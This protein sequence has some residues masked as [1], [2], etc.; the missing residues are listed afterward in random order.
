MSATCLLVT[1]CASQFFF[2]ATLGLLLVPNTSAGGLITHEIYALKLVDLDGRT[3]LTNDG[4]VTVVVLTTRTAI[5]KA[6]LVGARVPDYCLGNPE[7]RMITVVSFARNYGTVARALATALIRHR[8]NIDA[9]QLQRRYDARGVHKDARQDVFVVAD[10]DGTISQRLGA[11]PDAA[12]FR[13]FVFGR[14]G[15]LLREWENVP[16]AEELVAV[17]R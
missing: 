16:G 14:D 4:H 7:Y 10:F 15:E 3:L 9:A 11:G 6:Q 13:V 1:R 5:A 17:V 2:F 12:A 8:I